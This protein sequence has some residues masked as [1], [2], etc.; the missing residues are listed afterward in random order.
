MDQHEYENEQT[1][2]DIAD[3]LSERILKED[4]P[5][6]MHRTLH[7]IKQYD[8]VGVMLAKAIEQGDF[9]NLEGAGK[10]L[11]LYEN[12]CEPIELR[13]VHKILKDNGYAPDWIE[14]NKEINSLKAKLDKEINSFKKYTQIV[15]SEKRNSWAI[16]RYEQKK[17]NFYILIRENLEEISKKVLDYN[18]HCPVLQL[19]RANFNIENE[20]NRIFGDIEKLIVDQKES[21]LFTR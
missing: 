18:L 7:L 6:E 2:W 1:K 12:P 20:M 13:M 3:K 5:A 8:L 14:L 9:D 11:D 10:P 21:G 4:Y 17:K 19:G 15:F 16:K